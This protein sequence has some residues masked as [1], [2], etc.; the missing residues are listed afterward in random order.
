VAFDPIGESNLSTG[1]DYTA[2]LWSARSGQPVARLLEHSGLV[3]LLSSSVDGTARLWDPETGELLGSPL[4]HP[5]YVWPAV[6]SP[7][8]QT[9]TTAGLEPTAG[10]GKCARTS[11]AAGFSTVRGECTPWRSVWIEAV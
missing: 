5:G 7:D 9:I 11:Q 6:F 8:G 1:V 10:S 4:Q 2:R 3:S